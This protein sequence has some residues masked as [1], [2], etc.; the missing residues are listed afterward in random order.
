M[1]YCRDV[2]F[3]DSRIW[4]L[5]GGGMGKQDEGTQGRW[6]THWENEG[7]PL[8]PPHPLHWGMRAQLPGLSPSCPTSG[9]SGSG[10]VT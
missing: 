4:S 7:S 8:C 1:P 6:P 2:G 5:G 10:Q 3:G 9:L